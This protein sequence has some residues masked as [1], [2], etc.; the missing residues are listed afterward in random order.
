M[1]DHYQ[2]T[3]EMRGCEEILEATQA[4]VSRN[5]GISAPQCA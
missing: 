1:K 2:T 5:S 3:V 4:W